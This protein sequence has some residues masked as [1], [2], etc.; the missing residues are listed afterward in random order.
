M[1]HDYNSNIN[2]IDQAGKHSSYKGIKV[3]GKRFEDKKYKV[4]HNV[5]SFSKSDDGMNSIDEKTNDLSLDNSK[6]RGSKGTLVW[7]NVSHRPNRFNTLDEED[8]GRVANSAE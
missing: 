2:S 7:S 8:R 6:R 1:F 3:P 5:P 4:S